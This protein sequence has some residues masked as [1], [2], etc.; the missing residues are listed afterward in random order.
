MELKKRDA[1]YCNLKFVLMF[2]VV[3]GH[4]IEGRMEES[5]F[6]TQVY[7]LIYTVHMPLFLFLSGFL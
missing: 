4:L 3:Y 6:L 5:V 7:R 2:L 1:D